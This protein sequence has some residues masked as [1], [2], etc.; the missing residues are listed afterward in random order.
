METLKE[1]LYNYINEAEGWVTKGQLFLLAEQNGY[2]PENGGRRARELVN[3]GK[4][5]VSYY[6]GKKHQKLARYAKIGERQQI[7][8]PTF[9]EIERDG[10]R[11]VIMS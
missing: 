11:V 7:Y 6:T 1:I 10:Q 2:S 4:I 9:K 5:Q 8:K 3:E